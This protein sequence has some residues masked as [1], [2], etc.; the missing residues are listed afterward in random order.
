MIKNNLEPHI[1]CK[2]GQVATRVILPGDPGRVL[3]IAN[4]LDDYKE[5]SFNR[6]YRV[7]TGRYRNKK[8]TICSTGIGGPS[9]AIA[10][11]ELISLGAKYFIRVGSCGS[12]Q[13]KIKIGDL[14][15]SDSVVREDHTCLDYVSLKYPAIADPELLQ[16]MKK[17][18]IN[19][20]FRHHIG[21]TVTVDALFSKRTKEVKNYWQKFNTLAQD[22]EASTVLTLARLKNVKAGV[23]LLAVNKEGEKEIKNKIA[24]YSIQAKN[25]QG[26]LV[27]LEEKAAKLAL[28]SLCLIK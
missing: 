27:K 21:L 8:I 16:T 5:I 13:V 3:R 7:V 18:A 11:E 23:V 4:L 14:V 25:N 22:M 15:I 26:Q 12:N 24:S 10:M 20:K 2:K 17:T 28:E 19:L 1:L 9:T 6:E